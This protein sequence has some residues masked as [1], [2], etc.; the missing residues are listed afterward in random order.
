LLLPEMG[1]G[2]KSDISRGSLLHRRLEAVVASADI[3]TVP[4][5]LATLLQHVEIISPTRFHIGGGEDIEASSIA[6]PA[7]TTAVTVGQL[8]VLRGALS[9]ALYT[10]AYARVYAGEAVGMELLRRPVVID[11]AF[12]A[13]LSAANPT[14]MRWEPGWSVFK[15]EPTGAIHLRK[16][17]TATLAYPGQYAFPTG[18][19]R[20]PVVGETVDLLVPRES[21][22]LQPGMYFAFGDTVASDYDNARISRL[23]FSAGSAHADWL[24]HTLGSALNRYFV[25]FRLKCSVDPAQFDRTDSVVLY[26]ARRFLPVVLRLIAP[27]SSELRCRLQPGV[28]LFSKPLLPGLGAADDPATGESFGQTRSRIIADGIVDAWQQGRNSVQERYEAIIARF[29]RSGLSPVRPYLAQGLSDLYILP[30]A[31]G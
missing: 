25:P 14:M 31:E 3:P 6:M 20:P 2:H 19:G 23:Y 4:Q 10:V 12:V 16:G 29:S 26:V 27:L 1:V 22:T 9:T 21:V 18:N 8:D 24:L 15:S 7:Q 11:N 17:D 28:P 13:V 30:T 5:R